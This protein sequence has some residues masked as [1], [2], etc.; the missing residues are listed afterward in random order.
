MPLL[1]WHGDAALKKSTVATMAAHRK[2]DTLVQGIYWENGKGCAVGCLVHGPCP[3]LQ[4][5]E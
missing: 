5:A 3:A 1:A 2:A 4:E